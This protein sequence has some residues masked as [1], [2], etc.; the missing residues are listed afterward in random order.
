MMELDKKYPGYGW[1]ENAGYGTA[2]H[3]M[4]LHERGITPHHRKTFAPV[5]ALLAA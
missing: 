2:L 4:A 1:A 3:R 5:K